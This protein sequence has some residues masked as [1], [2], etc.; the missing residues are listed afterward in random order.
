MGLR[1]DTTCGPAC[2]VVCTQVREA[3]GNGAKKSCCQIVRRSWLNHAEESGRLLKCAL[4][5]SLRL[6]VQLGV[7]AGPRGRGKAR[8]QRRVRC[9]GTLMVGIQIERWAGVM[10]EMC[11]A[12]GYRQM[13]R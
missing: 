3:R 6:G 12:V 4:A 5:H 9:G 11:A 10:A 8:V 7:G 13:Y 1:A 2:C